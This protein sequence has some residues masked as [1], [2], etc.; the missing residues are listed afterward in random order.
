M[1]KDCKCVKTEPF[2]RVFVCFCFG[3]TSDFSVKVKS[4]A[5]L[6][7]ERLLCVATPEHWATFLLQLFI[8]HNRQKK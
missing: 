4:C 1:A 5:R 3:E 6:M 7:H 8:S 2:S